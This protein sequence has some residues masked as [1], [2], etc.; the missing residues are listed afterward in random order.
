MTTKTICGITLPTVDQV[1]A[2]S[3]E[4]MQN[5]LGTLSNAKTELERTR[6]RSELQLEHL[7][8]QENELLAQIKDKFGVSTREE[9]EQISTKSLQEFADALHAL[10]ADEAPA[11][12]ISAASAG[13][14]F[15]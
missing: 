5:F 10:P 15:E 14:A 7:Q 2:M 9:L 12:D 8:K 3:P 6:N 4:Q 13:S 1:K 11:T